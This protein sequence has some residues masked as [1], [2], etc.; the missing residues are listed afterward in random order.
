MSESELKRGMMLLTLQQAGTISRLRF[1]PG[2]VLHANGKRL[3]KY[4]ADFDYYRDGD[5]IVED[6]KGS[7]D[8]MTELARWKMK[9]FSAEYGTEVLITT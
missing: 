5:Y 8:H 7:E 4:I 1:Q 9:H 3:G 6:V 2:F